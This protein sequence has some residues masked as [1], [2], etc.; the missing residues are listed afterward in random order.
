MLL[1]VREVSDVGFSPDDFDYDTDRVPGDLPATTQFAGFRL[2]YPLNLQGKMDE[3]AEFLGASYF[4]ILGNRNAMAPPCA[5]W[6]STP[7]SRRAR[8][9]R[10]SRSS[11]SKNLPSSPAACVSMR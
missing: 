8:N 9:F 4:R 3:V 6:Q 1:T 11:G 2:L 10:G 5:A 7:R